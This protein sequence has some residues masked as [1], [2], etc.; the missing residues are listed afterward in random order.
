MLER[1][2]GSLLQSGQKQSY[3]VTWEKI[4]V[5]VPTKLY[6]H[7]HTTWQSRAS[8]KEIKLMTI[9]S[10]EYN[11]SEQPGQ[12]LPQTANNQNVVLN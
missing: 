1:E 10:S 3:W 2:T 9:Q 5:E 8:S 12:K 11:M 4:A 6:I 7:L